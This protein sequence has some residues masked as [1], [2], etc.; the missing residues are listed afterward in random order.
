MMKERKKN[1]ALRTNFVDSSN[2]VTSHFY[3]SLTAV[4]FNNDAKAFMRPVIDIV[5]NKS[6]EGG[7]IYPW[8][9]MAIDN[10][11]CSEYH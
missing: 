8:R 6:F 4:P 10:V 11:D 7:K 2:C 9:L 3:V 5:T 1:Y